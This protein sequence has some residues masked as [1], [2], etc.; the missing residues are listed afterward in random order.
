MFSIIFKGKDSK[1]KMFSIIFKGKDFKLKMFSIIFK[2]KYFLRCK[3]VNQT[4]DRPIQV[5]GIMG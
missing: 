4:Q 3:D 1:L 5:W 2:G